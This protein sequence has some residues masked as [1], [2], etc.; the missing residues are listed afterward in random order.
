MKRLAFALVTLAG[1]L[2]VT[3]VAFADP[4]ADFYNFAYI[5]EG[6]VYNGGVQTPEFIDI[7]GSLVIDTTPVAPVPQGLYSEVTS[8]SP[9]AYQVID[10][11]FTF[12]GNPF[13]LV[14][15]SSPGYGNFFSYPGETT[16]CGGRYDDLLY[17]ELG[18]GYYLGG[19][20]LLFQDTNGDVIQFAGGNGLGG[21][22]FEETISDAPDDYIGTSA[23]GAFI[24][25]TPE[26]SSW[27]LLGTG[28]VG[29]AAILFRKA[30]RAKAAHFRMCATPPSLSQGYSCVTKNEKLG[31]PIPNQW[32]HIA[33]THTIRSWFAEASQATPEA[34][35]PS[36]KPQR[37]VGDS[38][39]DQFFLLL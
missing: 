32:P 24:I 38:L 8:S 13:V 28:L 2:S 25:S 3:P 12:D 23:K 16:C 6:V 19:F 33:T 15:V 26:P 22:F 30:S 4:I 7:T 20:G 35:R 27:L 39:G 1:T 31:T 36:L 29:L 5:G 14:P 17:P 37:Q 9:A 34:Y 18:D 21:D 10:G 11:G